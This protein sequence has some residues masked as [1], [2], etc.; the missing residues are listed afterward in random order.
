MLV[1]AIKK[2]I[3]AGSRLQCCLCSA[4]LD[5]ITACKEHGVTSGPG[6]FICSCH[7]LLTYYGCCC[8]DPWQALQITMADTHTAI[9]YKF[10]KLARASLVVAEMPSQITPLYQSQGAILT[11]VP[12]L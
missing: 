2:Q 1:L 8:F 11:C 9:S 7:A 10:E 5:A 3:G 6:L 12:L 4:L